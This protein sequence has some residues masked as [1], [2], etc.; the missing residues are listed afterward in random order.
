[1]VALP[2]RIR[3]RQAMGVCLHVR[4]L[5]GQERIAFPRFSKVNDLLRAAQSGRNLHLANRSPLAVHPVT[6]NGR[7]CNDF[8]NAPASCADGDTPSPP[9]TSTALPAMPAT[10]PVPVGEASTATREGAC[11]PPDAIF[12]FFSPV[13]NK[14]P[15][16][17]AVGT[18]A[19]AIKIPLPRGRV[20]EMVAVLDAN[21]PLLLSAAPV[22]L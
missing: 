7:S 2:T 16:A 17:G 10:L 18:T 8:G 9:R 4:R 15:W 6:D 21:V 11:P 12:T 22:T 1:M 14:A 20:S 5:L 13:F 19:C 3:M